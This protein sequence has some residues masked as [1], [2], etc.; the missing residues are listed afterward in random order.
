MELFKQVSLSIYKDYIAPIIVALLA[1]I[2]LL[3]YSKRNNKNIFN[4]RKKESSF[5]KLEHSKNN[6]TTKSDRI[7]YIISI[8]VISIAIILASFLTGR[9]IESLYYNKLQNHQSG[10]INTISTRNGK[11]C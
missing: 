5:T 7:T 3:A 10:Y 9:Y 2:I 8:F 4:L 6:A 1:G 11:N